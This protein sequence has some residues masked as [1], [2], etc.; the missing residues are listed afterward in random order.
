MTE[1]D[2]FLKDL[3]KSQIMLT[4]TEAKQA[5]IRCSGI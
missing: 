4:G 3:N 2:K 5:G 1:K